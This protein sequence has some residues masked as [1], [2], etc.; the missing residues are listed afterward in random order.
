MVG[1]VFLRDRRLTRCNHHFEQMLGYEPGELV[2][3][4]SRR[5]YA[6]DAAWEEV[7]RRCYPQLAAGHSYEGELELC[8][9]D[10]TPVICEVRT[11]PL[12]SVYSTLLPLPGTVTAAPC[13]Q[14]PPY[15]WRM[16]A[17]S[18]GP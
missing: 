13:V 1:I 7:G 14:A 11:L 9:K 16:A 17:A 8:R 5:W 15:T 12:A 4:P 3:S 2:G 10:G 6:S 18:N